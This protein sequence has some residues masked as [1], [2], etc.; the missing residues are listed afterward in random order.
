MQKIRHQKIKTKGILCDQI[1]ERKKKNTLDRKSNV[2]KHCF[3]QGCS[4]YY[5]RASEINISRQPL[6]VLFIL[7][8]F[9]SSFYIN[10]INRFCLWIYHLSRFF[11]DHKRFG[12]LYQIYALRCPDNP[13]KS[14]YRYHIL[15][16]AYG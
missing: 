1:R 9:Y 11:P 13:I 16:T 4:K 3:Y 6:M 10:F 12:F 7:L 5:I 15:R 14:S 2:K 8:K